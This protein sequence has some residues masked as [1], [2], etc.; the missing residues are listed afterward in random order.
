M[1]CLTGDIHHSSLGINDQRYIPEPGVS[2]AAIAARYMEL[3]SCF[4]LKVTMYITGRTFVEDWD[5]VK[6]VADSPLVEIGG[7]TYSGL[8]RPINSR[9]FSV[10][11]GKT[12][13]S[14]GKSHGSRRRQEADVRRMLRA[15][16][17]RTGKNVA[18]WRSHGLVR[19][20]HTYGILYAQG[21]RYISDELD[22]EKIYPYQ[23][24]EGLIS[25]PMNVIMDHDH[26]YH[27]H[28]TRDFVSRITPDR[29]F[30]DDPSSESY[31]IDE[32]AEIVMR[33]VA[34]IE[35]RGGV[36]T[37]LMH[38]LCMYLADQFTAAER[39]LKFFSQLKS[40]WARETGAYVR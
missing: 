12:S 32:W 14:H 7:H 40:I 8:P 35:E 10:V 9:I 28:R 1:I 37:V 13:L 4:G 11:T 16:K 33:Q 29:V 30:P 39:L 34:S 21:I 6:P 22:W 36:S 20:K 19:D 31:D 15:V 18:S 17:A 25:H 23:T 5:D 26:L 27:A 3:V 24:S 2:E 38:P